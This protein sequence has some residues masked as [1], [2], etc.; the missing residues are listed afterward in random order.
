MFVEFG[1]S[2][3]RK[4]ELK[5]KINKKKTISVTCNEAHD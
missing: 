3:I 2:S 1:F 5:K 4:R